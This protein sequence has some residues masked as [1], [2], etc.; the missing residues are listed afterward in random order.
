[1]SLAL[2]QQCLDALQDELN[3]Q[4]FNT[5]VRPLQ[6]EEGDSGELCLLAPNRFV[7]DWV[8][9]KYLKRIHELLRELAPG[10]PPKV[11][12]SVGSRRTVSNPRPEGAA[13]SPVSAQAQAPGQI[14]KSQRLAL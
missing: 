12:L 11:E 2:W 1:M 5:W 9:D 7:R 4:Q 10:K 6:A 8:N 14:P 3:S 13:A